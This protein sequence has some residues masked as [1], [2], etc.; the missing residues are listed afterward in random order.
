[1]ARDLTTHRPVLTFNPTWIVGDIN[2]TTPENDDA[3]NFFA[4]NG[5]FDDEDPF[6]SV[7]KFINGRLVTINFPSKTGTGVLLFVLSLGKPIR[8]FFLDPMFK[9]DPSCANCYFVCY[10]YYI[11]GREGAAIF[12]VNLATDYIAPVSNDARNDTI[13]RISEPDFEDESAARK[14]VFD[15]YDPNF[16]LPRGDHSNTWTFAK[17]PSCKKCFYVMRQII[18]PVTV[19]SYRTF[20]CVWEVN[21]ETGISQPLNRDAQ[22]AFR[23]AGTRNPY[24]TEYGNVLEMR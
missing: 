23:L 12:S 7:R 21:I 2:Q 24:E 6:V 11:E 22:V 4:R 20:N 16:P 9:R 1:M 18:Q 10:P 15:A 13:V 8:S 5:M 17:S 19:N 3:K 14:I